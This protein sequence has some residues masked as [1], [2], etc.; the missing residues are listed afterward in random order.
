MSTFNSPEK[1][2][3]AKTSNIVNTSTQSG[4][5][6][7]NV[8]LNRVKNQPPSLSSDGF[9]IV[10][11]LVFPAILNLKLVEANLENNPILK[12]SHTLSGT[13]TQG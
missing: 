8:V 3:K 12:P 13:A 6:N 4:N 9:R 5:V 10:K 1:P 7:L 2:D 11:K